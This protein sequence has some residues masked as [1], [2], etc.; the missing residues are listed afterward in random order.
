MRVYEKYIK[1]Q[2]YVMTSFVPKG[3]LD[4]AVEGGDLA[5]VYVEEIVADVSNEEVSQGE[6]AEY[7]KTPSKY[8]SLESEFGELPLFK[9]PE[10]WTGNLDN[11]MQVSGMENDELPALIK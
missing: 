11:S 4:L 8:G 5:E 10:T 3:Q 6:E 9:S 1:N 7:E 2:P